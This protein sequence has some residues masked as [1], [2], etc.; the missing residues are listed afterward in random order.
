MKKLVIILMAV[1]FVCFSFG[2]AADLFFSE[3]IEGGSF[4]K[5]LEIYNGTGAEVDLS[6]YVMRGNHNGSAWEEV[7]TFGN[8]KLADGDVYVICHSAAAAEILA[9]ADTIV[10]DPYNGG[11]S[12][13]ANFNGDDVRAL[14]KVNG[15]DTTIIDLFGMYDLTDPGSGWAVAGVDN[16][17]K[18]HTLVRKQSVTTGNPDWTASAG[19]NADDSEWIVYDKDIFTYL[20]YHDGPVV[21]LDLNLTFEDDTDNAN[22]GVYD[23]VAGYT[24]VSHNATG[25]V[26]GTGAIEFGDGG[27]QFTIKRPIIATVGTNFQ[28][29]VDVKTLGWDDGDTFPITI[30]IEGIVETPVS[31]SINSLADFTNIEL[32]G[33]TTQ[34]SGYIAIVGSNTLAA[35]VGGEIKVWLDNLVFDDDV[36]A[37]GPPQVTFRVNTSTMGEGVTDSTGVMHIRGD[38]NGWNDANPMTN[39]G[40]D[41]WETTIELS[42]GTY[43]FK[44]TYTDNITGGLK[45]ESIDNRSVTVGAEDMV[46]DLAYFDNVIP[47]TPTD[48]VDVWF[49]VNMAGV[50]DYDGTSPV[51]VRGA[52]PIDPGWATA[53]E[54]VKEGETDFYSGLVSFPVSQIGDTVAYKFVWGPLSGWDDVHWESPKYDVLPSGDRYVIVNS[55][56]TLAFKYFN[57]APPTTD[58]KDYNVTIVMNTST[59]DNVTDSTAL[60]FVTGSYDGWA[61]DDDTLTQ[62]GDYC[63]KTFTFTGPGSGLD[64]EFTFFYKMLATIDQQNWQGGDNLK[65]TI[66]SDTTLVYYWQN[67]NTPPYTPT[68]SIDV[69]FR[70][71]MAGVADYDG[72]SP[73][74]VR[75]AIPLDPGWATAQELTQ[76]GESDYYSGLISFPSSDVDSTRAYKFVWGPLSGWDNVHWESPKYD[77]L[78]SGDRYINLKN[79][80]TLAFKY[81]SD[82]PPG[83]LD[84]VTSQ[85][86]FFVD[87][88][89][90]EELGLFS[91][92]R[93][94]SMQIRGSFNGW[95]DGNPLLCK[96]VRQP[97]TTIYGIVAEITDFPEKEIQYK[98]YMKMSTESIDY[99]KNNGIND[100]HV[101]WGYEVP[102]TMGGGN[103]TMIYDGVEGQIQM[104]DV[105]F[106]NGLPARGIIPT[107]T[108]VPVTFNIDMSQVDGFN[109]ATDSVLFNFKDEWQ[110]NAL[111]LRDSTLKYTDDDGDGVY[112][113]T[114]D[115]EGPT[116]Y[117]LIY[118][119]SWASPDG[120]VEEGGGFDYGRFRC[121]YIEPT[122]TNPITWPTAYICP[123]DVFTEDPP[124]AVEE[125]PLSGVGLVK[126][127]NVVVTEFKLEQNFPNPFNPTTE[128]RFSIPVNETT[129]LTIYNM[130]GQIVNQ[131]KYDNV[132]IGNYSYTWNALDNNGNKV[133]TGVYFYELRVGNRFN[134]TKKMLLLK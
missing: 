129:T 49:R 122:S 82:E 92:A 97:G 85:V 46:V 56:T 19:T 33:T 3:Y 17:T 71:N 116:A 94:D 47:Y 64:L 63:A 72:T 59:M 55:D 118:T 86:A 113:I 41:Y 5:A 70:V 67:G 77:V 32:S 48:T 10:Q 51:G 131:V 89:A 61:H 28:L 62:V 96:M 105:A 123:T 65:P 31:A 115:F 78:Q 91:V 37:S 87:M 133:S 100:I 21:N 99:W 132:S 1:L 68:D 119:V 24:T 107:E 29:S 66:T 6:N 8:A 104:I 73:V 111:G 36:Q 101:D 45:W 50:L 58:I 23:G 120:T 69:W 38:M 112:T 80:T 4:N 128:I 2:Q 130:L 75:G 52:I 35:N 44:F 54:M 90:Y 20:G 11:T 79:D 40:G 26:D 88:G 27:Y 134:E 93:K 57:D 114:I 7:F 14:C 102:P 16:G 39:V 76:E 124:L 110:V 103:R 83:D 81:Y 125:P 117:T 22:W 106:Y 18:D 53:V 30:A 12:N 109:A 42:E 98:F 126:E 84:P 34:D 74:G 25:G 15:T 127:N 9:E 95:N 13:A 43:G 108:T 121:R 60:F